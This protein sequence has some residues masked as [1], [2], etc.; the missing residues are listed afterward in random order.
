M[1][2]RTIILSRHLC[3]QFVIESIQVLQTPMR[4][5]VSA[6]C[7]KIEKCNPSFEQIV[8]LKISSLFH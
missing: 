2:W 4:A 6:M 3:M 5:F 1:L 7:F 8:A